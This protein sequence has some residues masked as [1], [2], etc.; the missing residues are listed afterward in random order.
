MR[1]PRVQ[2]CAKAF[3][4]AVLWVCSHRAHEPDPQR[5]AGPALS[6]KSSCSRKVLL[7]HHVVISVAL[8]AVGDLAWHNLTCSL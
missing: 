1:Y 7:S 3:A 8:L 4:P 6:Y 2:G 5:C